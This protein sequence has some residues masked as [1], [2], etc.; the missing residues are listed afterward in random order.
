MPC[1]F[2]QQIAQRALRRG[3]IL[4]QQQLTALDSLHTD[5]HRIEVKF[6][7]SKALFDFLP[8][9]FAYRS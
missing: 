6:A 7:L 4:R 9:R 5:H 2:L 3:G 1:H 8:P